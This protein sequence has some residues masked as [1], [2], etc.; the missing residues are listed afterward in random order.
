MTT[1]LITQSNYI[2]WRGYFDQIRRSDFVIT[3]DV[4]QYT[5]RDWRNRN[6]IKTP[7]GAQWMTIPVQTKSRYT[8]AIDETLVTDGTWV[9]KHTDLLRAH[10]GEAAAFDTTGEA[11]LDVLRSLAA[12]ER[13]SEVNHHLLRW[14]CDALGF[15]VP[16]SRCEEH[17][18]RATLREMEP[19]ERLVALAQSVNATRYLSGPA[20]KAYLDVAA[21]EAVGIDVAWMDYDGYPDYPQLWGEFEPHV[22]IVDLLFNTGTEARNFIGRREG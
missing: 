6:R 13:L 8:Q 9:Q 18:D 15:H 12:V 17:I 16:I 21:F 1:V 20:A 22:S 19:T 4:V 3:L 11:F 2:P 10:Y 7:A 14:A 5:R